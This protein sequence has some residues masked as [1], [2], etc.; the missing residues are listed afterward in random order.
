MTVFGSGEKKIVLRTK[1]EEKAA[2]T[3]KPFLF[4]RKILTNDGGDWESSRQITKGHVYAGYVVLI[5]ADGK[6][7]AKESNES[8]FLKD[9]W[10]KRVL[11]GR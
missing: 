3:S 4:E 10:I 5:V 6:I 1:A 8:R 11:K 2:I 7:L 9:K